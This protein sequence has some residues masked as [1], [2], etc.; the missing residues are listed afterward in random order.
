MPFA[1]LCQT[2][3]RPVKPIRRPGHDHTEV[4]KHWKD[5]PGS[6]P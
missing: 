6:L 1:A 4:A 3:V 5:R 2:S